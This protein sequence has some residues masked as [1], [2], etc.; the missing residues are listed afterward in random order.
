MCGSSSASVPP[1]PPPPPIQ[2]PP[3][4]ANKQEIVPPTG[5]FDPVSSKYVFRRAGVPKFRIES[6]AKQESKTSGEGTK[7][8]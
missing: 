4:V 8:E 3:E 6:S 5:M 2:I 1:P 7:P